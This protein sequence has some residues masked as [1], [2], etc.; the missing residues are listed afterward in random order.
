M[1]EA[2]G[3][4]STTG[5]LWATLAGDGMTSKSISREY[6]SRKFGILR[7]H[8]NALQTWKLSPP[9]SD[10]HY[11]TYDPSLY[12]ASGGPGILG[13]TNYNPP[14]IDA[15]VESLPSIGIPIILDLNGGNN[16]GGKHELNTMNPES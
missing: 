1:D 2:A 3:L 5:K 16:I 13:Y 15:F 7:L 12:N 9:E 6:V 11:R 8:I 4:F 14:V 10:A